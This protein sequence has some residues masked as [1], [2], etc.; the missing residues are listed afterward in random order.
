MTSVVPDREPHDVAPRAA[1]G[2]RPEHDVLLPHLVDGCLRQHTVDGRRPVLRSCPSPC[3]RCGDGHHGGAFRCGHAGRR[4]RTCRTPPAVRCC[5]RRSVGAEFEGTGVPAELDESGAGPAVT[6]TFP[7]GAASVDGS[8]LRTATSVGL[9]ACGGVRR[10][11]QRCRVPERRVRG[12]ARPARAS[13]GRCSARTQMTGMLQAR[14][15]DAGGGGGRCRAWARS[16]SV[17]STC[18]G[19]SGTSTVRFYVD[20]ALVH[21]AATVSGSMR[22]LA[23]D[24]TAGG[25]GLVTR[26][27]CE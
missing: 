6:T 5:W 11:V 4:R 12:H 25:G 20:G 27:G 13:R 18:S 1:D 17:R 16:S 8:W 7:G 19:S 23:S 24:Y 26:S 14:T 21:T 10:H 3:R 2:A 15:R 22:P 9:G